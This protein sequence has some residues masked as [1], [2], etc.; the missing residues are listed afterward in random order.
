MNLHDVVCNGTA[1]RSKAIV[2]ECDDASWVFFMAMEKH[3]DRLGVSP[4]VSSMLHTNKRRNGD[5]DPSISKLLHQWKL[6]TYL[7]IAG[8]KVSPLV[9]RVGLELNGGRAESKNHN[10][11]RR[12]L[13]LLPTRCNTS[14]SFE[15]SIAR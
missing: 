13:F 11:S 4:M 15:G 10:M 8:Y 7:Q 2:E 12:K 6:P 9:G 1:K 3:I 14:S 5:V